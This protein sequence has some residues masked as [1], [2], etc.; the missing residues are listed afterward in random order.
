MDLGLKGRRALVLA[1][2]KGLGFAVAHALAGEGAAVA[3][4][5]SHAGR[6]GQA[7]ERIARETGATAVGIAA[8]L[9]EP[10]EVERLAA[11]TREALGGIDILVVNHAGPALGLAAEIDVDALARQFRMVVANPIRL[12]R[13]VLPGMRARRWGRILTLGGVSMIQALPNKAMDNTLRP[14]M[15][16]FTK[17]LANEVARDGV[18]VNV[19][20]PGTFYTERVQSSTEANA[21]LFG[22][23]VEEA[24]RERIANIPMGRFG[25]LEEFG[26]LAAF[27]VSE[28]AA[29]LTG[30]VW[31]TDGGAIRSIV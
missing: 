27:L 12:I 29:Y 5:S 13:A 14:A 26:A 9:F 4:S 28:R 23:T 25:T 1:A 22:M 31:R 17:A 7:A 21:R 18:T 3:V 2:S 30:S 19:L 20:I 15:V 16:G 11:R 6:C 24:M 8:D 10:A